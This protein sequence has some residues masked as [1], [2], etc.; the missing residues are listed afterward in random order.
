MFYANKF[1]L[2]TIQCLLHN[3]VGFQRN[4]KLRLNK[5][6]RKRGLLQNDWK[7]IKG[8]L[9]VKSVVLKL[10]RK[11]TSALLLPSHSLPISQTT[12]QRLKS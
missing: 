4:A 7:R 2:F 8:L 11:A 12:A 3:H 1:V 9:L 6:E 10:L 5:S